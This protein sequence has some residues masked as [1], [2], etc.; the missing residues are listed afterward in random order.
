MIGHELTDHF[1]LLHDSEI[2]PGYEEDLIR[3]IRARIRRQPCDHRAQLLRSL[4]WIVDIDRASTRRDQ[5][6]RESRSRRWRDRVDGAFVFHHFERQH[7]REPGNTRFRCAIV[8]L[9]EVAVQAG[10]GREV[11]DAAVLPASLANVLRE[12]LSAAEMSL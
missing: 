3:H 12:W 7:T 5:L 8:R 1:G 10:C 4:Q 6:Q 11:H 9:T 2:A